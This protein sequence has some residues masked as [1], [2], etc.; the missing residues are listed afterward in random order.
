V[1]DVPVPAAVADGGDW[2][3]VES[4]T[5]SLG[6][7][8]LVTVRA[9]RAL[10]DDRGLRER[11]R[12]AT[13]RDRSWRTFFVSR[14]VTDPPLTPGIA[15]LVVRTIAVPRARSRLSADLADRGFAD[16]RELDRS[17]VAL[18]GRTGRVTR[19]RARL[20]LGAGTGP[21]GATDGDDREPGATGTDPTA[22][23][24]T[25]EALL[26]VWE[27]GTEMFAAGGTYP[28]GQ[29]PGAPGLFADPERARERLLALV[30]TI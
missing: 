16:V 12:E 3:L 8:R 25:V 6:H 29:L 21:D 7:A 23:A 9:H 5:D 10:Y 4:G 18:D 22:D 2:E 27:T 20:P 15:D 1:V 30:R 17:E 28:V 11:V 26:V 19:F 14:L 24:L 13:D